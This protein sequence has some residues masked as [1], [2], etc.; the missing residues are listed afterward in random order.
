MLQFPCF[1]QINIEILLFEAFNKFTSVNDQEWCFTPGGKWGNCKSSC[2]GGVPGCFKT[3][4][5]YSPT[6]FLG[7]RPSLEKSTEA[8]RARCEGHQKCAFFPS[9]RKICQR[10][11]VALCLEARLSLE[12]KPRHMN[13]SQG[14]LPVQVANFKK[15]NNRAF[16]ILCPGSPPW[17]NAFPLWQL[18]PTAKSFAKAVFPYDSQFKWQCITFLLSTQRRLNNQRG[19]KGETNAQWSRCELEVA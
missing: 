18:I 13:S 14:L 11:M 2:K 19:A 3:N 17:V 12:A 1:S 4:V 9:G 6:R 10:I 8:C 15:I 16:A 5:K 7:A